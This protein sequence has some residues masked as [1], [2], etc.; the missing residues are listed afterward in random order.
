MRENKVL[1]LSA[2]HKIININPSYFDIYR[3]KQI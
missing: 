3:S 1:Y 2:L